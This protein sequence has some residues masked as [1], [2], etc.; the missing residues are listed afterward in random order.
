[1]ERVCTYCKGSG[2]QM[3]ATQAASLEDKGMVEE[4]HGARV[5][6]E[7]VHCWKC[8]GTGKIVE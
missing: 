3:L 7:P 2:V 4:R 1:M 8:N 6:I 5:L